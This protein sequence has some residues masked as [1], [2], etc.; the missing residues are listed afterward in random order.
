MIAWSWECT[1]VVA[2]AVWLPCRS[3]VR[4]LDCVVVDLLLMQLLLMHECGRS[5]G[6]LCNFDCEHENRRQREE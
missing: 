3:S 6:P 5:V 1:P 2:L 4:C